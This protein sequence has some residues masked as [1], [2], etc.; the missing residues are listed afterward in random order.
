MV[1]IMQ[2]DAHEEIAS[3]I[4]QSQLP[5]KGEELQNDLELKIR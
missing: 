2:V 3:S 4:L 5:L 1:F